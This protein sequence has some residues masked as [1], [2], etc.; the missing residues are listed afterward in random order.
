MFGFTPCPLN[1]SI[2]FHPPKN[3]LIL[4]IIPAVKNNLEKC[5]NGPILHGITTSSSSYK[6]AEI[7]LSATL[8]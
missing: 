4:S 8:F 5:T 1:F 7:I 2:I 3:Q 6:I